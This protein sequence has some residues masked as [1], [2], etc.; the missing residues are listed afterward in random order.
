MPKQKI[1]VSIDRIIRNAMHAPRLGAYGQYIAYPNINGYNENTERNTQAEQDTAY[2]T[3]CKTT[4]NS[5]TNIRKVFI[6]GARVRVEYYA[7]PIVKDKSTKHFREKAYDSQDNLFNIAEKHLIYKEAYNAYCG[8][9]MIN[10]NAV[11]PDGYNISGN[12]LGAFANPYVCSNIEEI[13]FDWTI[14]LSDDVKAY[15]PE[16]M[17][18]QKLYAML[19][20]QTTF[21]AT[22]SQSV[23]NLFEAF[24]SGGAKDLRKRFP[25]LRYIALIS[26]L[27]DILTSGQAQ[28]SDLE[29]NNI[30]ESAITW[31]VKNA[32]LIKQSNS[33]VI[34]NDIGKDLDKINKNFIVKNNTFKFDDEKLKGIIDSHLT[35][36]DDYIRKQRYGVATEDKS[37]NSDVVTNNS[38]INNELENRLIAIEEELGHA[39]VKNILTIVKTEFKVSE[40]KAV[41]SNFTP[42]NRK[43]YA[44]M[45]KLE[46]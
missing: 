40:W 4:F 30:E 18:N 36:V 16:L 43:K 3:G 38:L 7:T 39:A 31:F 2:V 19:N 15:I 33:I 34:A 27:D 1:K 5:P 14:L 9:K 23:L 44:E 20:K 13:Y 11:E 35:K 6:T 22:E 21:S 28:H 29:F 37:D 26:N 24:N 17:D 10:P 45:I 8:E 25:R 46:L 12:G 32:E 41:L 42:K